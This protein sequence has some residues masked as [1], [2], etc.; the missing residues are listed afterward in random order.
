MKKNRAEEKV[1][2]SRSSQ[3][4]GTI[5]ASKMEQRKQKPQSK[6]NKSLRIVVETN[7]CIQKIQTWQ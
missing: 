3:S 5:G 1:D 6:E 7:M 4:S 2:S